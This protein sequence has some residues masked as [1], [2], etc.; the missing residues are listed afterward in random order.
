M[1]RLEPEVLQ[2]VL[3]PS[4][5][6]GGEWNAVVKDH[7]NMACTWALALPDVYEVGMSNLGLAILYEVLNQREDIAA[8]RVYTPWTDME[9][10]MRER[11]MPLFSLE[12]KTEISAFTFVGFSLQYEMI[13][14]NVLNMLDLAG[15]PLWSKDRGEDTPF[16][17]GGGPCVYNVE[18]IA[19]FFDFFLVGEGEEVILEVSDA[20]KTWKGEGK[21]GGRRGFLMRLLGIDGVYVPSFY[22]PEYD[23]E[24]NYASLKPL[25]EKARPVIY[26]RVLK[27]M[28]AATG[29]AHPVVP[30]MD[31]VHN[32]VMLELFRGCSRGC[33]FCQ[34][35]ICYRPV[36]ERTEPKLREMARGLVDCTGYNEMSLTS[37]SSA[38]Y[39]CLG[40]LVDDLM[41]DFH[42][43]KVSFS[44]PSL[45]IDSFSIGLAHKMQQVRKSGLTFAPEAGT[46]RLRDVIN[47]GVTEEDL[48]A[49]CGSAFRQG[50]KQ[51]KL[52]FMMGLPTETDE[53]VI[54]IADLAKKVVDLYTEI[55]GR[56]GVKVTISVACFVPKPYTPFQWFGQLPIE[57]FERRQHLLKEHITD[58]AITFN[59]HDARLSV[60]EGVFA[61]GDRRLAQVLW[62]AWKDGVKF[63]G[64][65]DLFKNEVWH[66][67]FRKCGI[68]MTYYNGRSRDFNEP[69]PWEITS[70]GVNKEFLLR[71]WHHAMRGQLTHD[72]RRSSCT[73]CGI[74]PNLGV[75]VIDHLK[76]E[77]G[78]QEAT[79]RD[80]TPVPKE[81]PAEKN[82]P[83]GPG[84][85]RTLYK[86]RAEIT[87]GDALRYVSHLDFA[88]LFIRAFDRA[89]LP[90][91]YSEGFNPHMKISFASALSLGVDSE[92]EYMDFEL[93]KELCQPE[94][95]DR[96]S[97][98]LPPGVQLLRLKQVKTKHKAL[99]A[100]TDEA[101]YVLH[102]PYTGDIRLAEQAVIAYNRAPE[103]HFHRVTP[104]KTREI[105]TKQY[106]LQ[107]VSFEAGDGEIVLRMDI[108]IT[109][110]GSVKPIEVL[111]AIIENFGLEADYAQAR[112]TRT[113][114]FGRG[115]TLLDLVED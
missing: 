54:G 78:E 57:E 106:M 42:D 26:K 31:I 2:T 28:D 59:Y 105:E 37:L 73:G 48:M 30:Y 10:I 40:T 58:R 90:M 92:A 34:A 43:E 70:P 45:R 27:D 24:G 91:A 20:Y 25:S 52:Y 74:C 115:R 64:W 4:R 36:R 35:G 11:H 50:W 95:F 23:A 114:L 8:E 71:E 41:A 103:V 13:Y 76:S 107:P 49:A 113:G 81:K 80:F 66:E 33:R 62:Q 75:N 100:E 16:I 110:A 94:V 99:M 1:V 39:S 55:K 101:R 87:K 109:Q 9:A 7:A 12:T 86:Y 3:K 51:V 5:Y 93:V 19:D 88:D 63:D 89:K 96:L 72:C 112:I 82:D 15:I 46:Q 29:V 69:L 38:D 102:I 44:L 104:K 61:R 18:P 21:P 32:R 47:K 56:R 6:T 14:S 67:A 65:S 77:T 83:K 79:H 53:D 22:E 17:V 68:D 85:P 98:Q 84:K 111:Q 97:A 60:I 108:R